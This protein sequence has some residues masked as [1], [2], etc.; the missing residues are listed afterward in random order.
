MCYDKGRRH[1]RPF[2][3]NCH[4]LVTQVERPGG[5]QNLPPQPGIPALHINGQLLYQ[6]HK[7]HKTDRC[8]P[9]FGTWGGSTST[10]SGVQPISTKNRGSR[11]KPRRLRRSSLRCPEENGFAASISGVRALWHVTYLSLYIYR[12]RYDICIYDVCLQKHMQQ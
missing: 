5:I 7:R 8:L 12:E 10:P 9:L 2:Q 6:G 3:G 1:F 4:P 11:P